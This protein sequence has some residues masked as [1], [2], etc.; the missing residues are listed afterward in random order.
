MA[1]ALNVPGELGFQSH[2]ELESLL[3]ETEAKFQEQEAK[4]KRLYAEMDNLRKRS[5]QEYVANA[6]KF[7]LEKMSRDLLQILDSLER[8]LELD[9]SSN[10][11]AMKVHEG[12]GLTHNLLLA[13]LKRYAIE[14]VNPIGQ[15]FDP[16][17]HESMTVQTDPNAKP[18]TVLQVLQKG[19]TLHGRL[20]RPALV[21]VAKN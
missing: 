20:L 10:E 19:Y 13:T 5:E 15:M 18:N 17:L 12:I 16:E 4:A 8:A 1:D 3:A 21:V 9:V 14:Q 7:G 11:L 2:Q 6:H